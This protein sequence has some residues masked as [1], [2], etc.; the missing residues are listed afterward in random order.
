MAAQIPYDFGLSQAFEAYRTI[1]NGLSAMHRFE[2]ARSK[3]TCDL[4][5]V[6]INRYSQQVRDFLRTANH[7]RAD[8]ER[9]LTR[10]LA[11]S[12]ATIVNTRQKIEILSR[13]IALGAQFLKTHPIPVF[14]IPL[15]PRYTET[16]YETLLK[17]AESIK[18]LDD[19]LAVHARSL[20]DLSKAITV[21]EEEKNPARQNPNS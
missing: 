8:S 1:V 16:G 10:N 14:D 18:Q 11:T 7:Q 6:N 9:M 2:H 4:V 15:N 3:A 19:R 12:M 20:R 21:V 17:H 5:A 13:Y